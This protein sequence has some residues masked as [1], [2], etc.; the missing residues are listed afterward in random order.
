MQQQLVLMWQGF[1][2]FNWGCHGIPERCLIIKGKR[3]KICARCLGAN[4]GHIISFALF[5]FWLLPSWYWGIIGLSI[6]LFDWAL[7][8]Y[9]NIMSNKYRR[10]VTGIIGGF[11]VGVLLWTGIGAIYD[12]IKNFF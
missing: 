12:F 5:I 2:N 10:V 1:K 3:M 4:L 9:F 7:Q 8:T 11:G 6:L